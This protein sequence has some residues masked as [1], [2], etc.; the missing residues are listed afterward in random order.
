MKTVPVL[1]LIILC[2]SYAIADTTPHWVLFTDRG[3]MDTARAIAAKRTGDGPKHRSRRAR[4]VH[5]D[6][7]FDETDLPVNP[8]HIASVRQYAA[9]VRTVS[10]FL[11]GVSVYLDASGVEAVRALPFVSE[12]RPV[13]IRRVRPEPPATEPM[14]RAERTAARGYGNSLDQV[15]MADIIRLHTEGYEGTGVRIAVLDSGF[16]WLEHAAFDSITIENSWDFV[17]RDADITDDDHG[18]EVLS[19]LAALDEGGMIGVAPYAVYLLART[20]IREGNDRVAEEDYWVAGIEWADSLGADVVN[21]SLG[22]T[23]FADGSGYTIDDLDGDTALTTIAADIAASKG[24]VVVTSAGNEGNDV[25]HFVTTPADAD[26]ILAVGAV[27]RNLK[28]TSFSSRGPTA[29]GRVKPDVM[30]LGENVWIMNSTV[31]DGYRYA[32]GTSYAAPIVSGAAALILEANPAWTGMNVVEALRSTAVDRG[33]AGPDSLYGYGIVSAFDASELTP[34]VQT[35]AAFKVYDPYPQPITFS[36]TNAW[37]RFPMDIPE[38]GKTLSI[39]IFTFTG[40]PVQTL[41]STV[42]GS[43]QLRFPDETPGWDG[44]NFLGDPVAPGIYYYTVHLYGYESH[45]GKLVVMR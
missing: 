10:R 31:A 15:S 45:V 28:V 38:E 12:V 43:G 44:T 30:A 27:D 19:V 26:S 3:D 6:H 1:L 39:R 14:P 4:T 16:D 18:T 35:S 40:D 41:R 11:N 17:A 34:T 37:I 5:A 33:I 9:R 7:L 24:V 42:I 36:G 21:S 32:N 25:W 13:A 23:T 8:D 29:D 20:E 2:S 22:Y